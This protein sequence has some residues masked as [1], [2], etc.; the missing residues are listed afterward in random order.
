[1]IPFQLLSDIFTLDMVMVNLPLAKR[2]SI[3]TK[4]SGRRT[5]PRGSKR[6]HDMT[7]RL[8]REGGS[9]QV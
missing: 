5:M 8:Q 2:N 6:G 9:Y 7:I 3:S 1:M 4:R